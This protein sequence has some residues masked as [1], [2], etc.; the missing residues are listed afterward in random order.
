MAVRLV[1]DE[2]PEA[3]LIYRRGT[4]ADEFDDVVRRT[5]AW[6]G[7][8]VA[9]DG[10]Y[11]GTLPHPRGFGCFARVLGEFVRRRGFLDVGSA[12]HKLSGFAAERYGLADRGR[13]ESGRAADLVVFDPATVDGPASWD[14]PRLPPVGIDA[15]VL[16][17]TLVVSG[18]SATGELAGRVLRRGR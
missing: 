3:V 5:L 18:G 11:H 7:F 9:S 13:I 15:V 12:I 1:L 8:M 10:L 17:G 14:E 4:P 16:N 2:T 6:P